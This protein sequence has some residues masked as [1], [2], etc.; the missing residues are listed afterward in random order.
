MD[1]FAAIENRRSVREFADE[2]V[3]DAAIERILDAGQ[4][5]PSAGNRQ[6]RAFVVVRDETGRRDLATAS[7]QR[8]LAAAPVIIA[9]CADRRRSGREYGERGRRLYAIQDATAAVQNMLL[10]IH[11]TGMGGCWVGAFDEE[12]VHAILD[13]PAHVRVIALIP[14]GHPAEHPS[15]PGRRPLSEVV[16]EDR[17]GGCGTYR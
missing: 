9:V 10:A 3:G 12:R 13:V 5:A 8:F 1:V 14:V 4:A 11:A 17:W 16:H 6:A 15:S 7:S 2:S